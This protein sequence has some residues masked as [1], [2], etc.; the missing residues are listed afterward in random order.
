M[1]VGA[2]GGRHRHS[3]LPPRG[4]ALG[5]KAAKAPAAQAGRPLPRSSA[6][7]LGQDTCSLTAVP[8]Q[9]WGTCGEGLPCIHR[10]GK[11]QL[12]RGGARCLET[13]SWFPLP[14]A[15]SC[16]Q[17]FQ[18]QTGSELSVAPSVLLALSPSGP[19][20]GCP[21]VH[22]PPLCSPESHRPTHAHG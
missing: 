17:T 8:R 3:E 12:A 19:P 20:V 15:L 11:P 4:A 14:P 1:G 2:M 9:S 13:E 10:I 16:L 21:C 22:L 6:S 7:S 5:E 18:G